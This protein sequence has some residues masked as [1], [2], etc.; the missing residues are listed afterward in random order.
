MD[1]YESPLSN[2]RVLRRA[3]HHSYI[4]NT[5]ILDLGIPSFL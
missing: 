1:R 3:Y 4:A 5:I 2:T